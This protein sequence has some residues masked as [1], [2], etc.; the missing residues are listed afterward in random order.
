MARVGTRNFREDFNRGRDFVV[1]RKFVYGT[2]GYFPGSTPIDKSGFTDRSLRQLY[3]GFWLDMAPL[4]IK[5]PSLP[6]I[7]G[8]P[9]VEPVE[10]PVEPV[11][12]GPALPK[13]N[14]YHHPPEEA[15]QPAAPE[16]PAKQATTPV[17]VVEQPKPR[18]ERRRFNVKG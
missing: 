12:A 17:Q 10:V 2:E 6:P 9:I 18:V 7:N 13:I 1:R 11:D 3:D 4:E 14:G 15:I 16:A 5:E 8:A